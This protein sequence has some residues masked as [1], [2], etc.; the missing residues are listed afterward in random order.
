MRARKGSEKRGRGLGFDIL[1]VFTV[2]MMLE[3]ADDLGLD[4]EI[5]AGFLYAPESLWCF[6][7]DDVVSIPMW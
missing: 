2:L 5:C 6:F 1:T 7:P 3:G 4:G